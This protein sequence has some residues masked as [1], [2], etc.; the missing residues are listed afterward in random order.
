M[1]RQLFQKQ[2]KQQNILSDVELFDPRPETRTRASVKLAQSG[3][4]GL[5]ANQKL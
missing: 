1:G 4:L 2:L 5:Q 3:A